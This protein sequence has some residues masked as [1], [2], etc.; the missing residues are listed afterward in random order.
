[1]KQKIYCY[2]DESGQDISSREFIAVAVI[3][4]G[5]V[6]STRH[7]QLLEIEKEAAT[8]GLKWHKTKLDRSLKYLGLVLD[9]NSTA[10]QTYIGYFKK[11][12]P[13]FFPIVD[14]IEAAIKQF[15]QNG[16]DY[17]A[18]IYVDGIDKKKALEL[19]NVLRSHAIRLR[20]V[21]SARD[22]SEPC[23]RLA[24]MWAGCARSALLGNR[25]A[26]KMM[27]KAEKKNSI[28]MITKRPL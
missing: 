18:T 16:T 7:N 9:Q 21:R 26:Q 3:L 12:T 2:F 25:E 4:T 17:Q 1:M 10:G 20:R 6:R 5:D 27:R 28:V 8:H 15:T 13:Y 23:I 19:T 22:E 24:D 11:P 14:T